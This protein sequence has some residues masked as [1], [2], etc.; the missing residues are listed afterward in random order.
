MW[1]LSQWSA[2][3]FH[4]AEAV[5]LSVRLVLDVDQRLIQVMVEA[6]AIPLT[7][8]LANAITRCNRVGI[9]DVPPRPLAFASREGQTDARVWESEDEKRGTGSSRNRTAWPPVPAGNGGRLSAT[10]AKQCLHLPHAGGGHLP[11][12]LGSPRHEPAD[13]PPHG[14]HIGI[15]LCLGQSGAL[16]MLGRDLRR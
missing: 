1:Q 3:G 14:V 5:T 6:L 11:A 15:K 12:R 8:A 4:D 16:Q 9:D 10:G 2:P 7:C 13:R